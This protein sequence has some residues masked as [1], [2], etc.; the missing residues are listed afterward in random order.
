MPVLPEIN[1]KGLVEKF[2][3][4]DLRH[5]VLSNPL[6]L[7]KELTPDEE[8]YGGAYSSNSGNSLPEQ[9]SALETY[10]HGNLHDNIESPHDIKSPFLV[11]N[12]KAASYTREKR[13]SLDAVVAWQL[14]CVA[15]N[16]KIKKQEP[17]N[18]ETSNLVDIQSLFINDNFE[19][20]KL[21]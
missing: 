18:V 19:T 10:I 17:L 4:R 9:E 14:A 20:G 8:K 11:L 15:V 1:K 3:K 21:S 6:K 12:E 5:F 7:K 2:H 13:G 16:R